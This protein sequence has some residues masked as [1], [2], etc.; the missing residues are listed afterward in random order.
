MLPELGKLNA[1]LK[2][3]DNFSTPKLHCMTDPLKVEPNVIPLEFWQNQDQLIWP[4]NEH[5]IQIFYYA[6]LI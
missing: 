5:L 3:G 2:K 1:S 6:K 4:C